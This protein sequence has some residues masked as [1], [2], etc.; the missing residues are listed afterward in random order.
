MDRNSTKA[1]E[2]GALFAG[3][4]WFNPLEAAVRGRIRIFIEDLLE[5]VCAV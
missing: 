1:A 2:A 5:D 4:A 3:E